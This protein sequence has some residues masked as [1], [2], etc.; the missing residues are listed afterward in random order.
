VFVSSSVV[1]IDAVLAF[2]DG[3]VGRVRT[4]E[5]GFTSRVSVLKI[6]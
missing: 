5:P 2:N 3:N 6:L 4:L 1:K